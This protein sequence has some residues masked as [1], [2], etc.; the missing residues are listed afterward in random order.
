MAL[1]DQELG[2]VLRYLDPEYREAWEQ[3]LLD[4]ADLREWGVEAGVLTPSATP[5]PGAVDQPRASLDPSA[6]G[7]S[8][9]E[10]MGS[11]V[12]KAQAGLQS[13][14][15][16]QVQRAADADYIREREEA[17]PWHRRDVFDFVGF[18]PDERAVASGQ[19]AA[20]ANAAVT[21]P[22]SLAP[23]SD[24]YDKSA[25]QVIEDLLSARTANEESAQAALEGTQTGWGEGLLETAQDVANSP[26][27]MLSVIGG[28]TAALPYATTYSREYLAARQ[29][30]LE[31]EDADKRAKVQAAI[32]GG[33]SAVPTGRVGRA[34]F[35]VLGDITRTAGRVAATAG[36]EAASET[37]TTAAQ[38]AAD[39]YMAENADSEKLRDYAQFN[40]P[41]DIT[42]LFDVLWRSFKAG[43]LGGTVM[44]T[45]MEI[46]KTAA[47]HGKLAA[48]T[49]RTAEQWAN[50]RP[51]TDD[52][53]PAPPEIEEDVA[54]TTAI[55]P[56][57][58]PEQIEAERDRAWEIRATE[59]AREA[60]RED[61]R[62]SITARVDQVRQRVEELQEAVEGGDRSPAT[63]SAFAAANRDL[64]RAEQVL[65]RFDVQQ[66]PQAPEL[67][68]TA[69]VAEE[70]SVPLGPEPPP[71]ELAEA[72]QK[73]LKSVSNVLK[74]DQAKVRKAALTARSKARTN[75]IRE[76]AASLSALNET[77][78]EQV[79]ADKLL[80]WESANPVENFY[81]TAPAQTTRNPR[82]RTQEPAPV[83]ET[84]DE[85]R[86]NYR[87][88]FPEATEQEI[89]QMVEQDSRGSEM[90]VDQ[91][92]RTVGLAN[93]S[94][95]ATSNLKVDDVVKSLVNKIGKGSNRKLA[96]MIIDGNMRIVETEADIPGGSVPSGTAGF[97]DGNTM[98]IVA[99]RLS[100]KNIVGDMLEIAAHE[101][102][103]AADVAPNDSLK[104]TMGDFVGRE[105]N[106]RLVRKI[107][108]LAARGN[109]V[110]Q[111]AVEQANAADQV[112]PGS[113]DLELTAYFI[114]EARNQRA[115]G[116]L[117]GSVMGDIVSA[118]RTAAKNILPGDYDIDVNDVAY[119]SD[120]LINT[121]AEQGSRLATKAD[122]FGLPMVMGE[123]APDFKLAEKEGRVYISKDGK[124]KFLMSDAESDL[125]LTPKI[126]TKL[127]RGDYLQL[128]EI[129]K[130]P[131][132]F[133]NYPKLKNVMVSVNQELEAYTATHYSA[134]DMAKIG[135][136][137][138]SIIDIS[139]EFIKD[140]NAGVS[141]E[142]V[143]RG[144]LLHEAQHEIQDIEESARGGN[145]SMFM[146]TADRQLMAK[147]TQQRNE[148]LGAVNRILSNT[149]A[150]GF[151][152]AAM[153]QVEKARDAHQRGVISHKELVSELWSAMNRPDNELDESGLVMK[154]VLRDAA[155][156]YEDSSKK[157]KQIVRDAYQK[158]YSLLGEQEAYNTQKNR[159]VRQEDLPINP[160]DP[161]ALGGF[162]DTQ[163]T[164]AIMYNGQSLVKTD[165]AVNAPIY[166]AMQG[167]PFNPQVLDVARERLL[168]PDNKVI[169]K[170]KQLILNY[171]GLGKELGQM[172]ERAEGMAAVYAHKGMKS[173]TRLKDGIE[174]MAKRTNQT[175]EQVEELI[176]KRMELI[177]D[178]PSEQRRASAVGAFIRENPELV[179][180]GEAMTEVTAL[181]K[182]LL[183]QMLQ[184]NSNPTPEELKLMNTINS[185]HY[186][187][188]TQMYSAFQG[189]EGRARNE[190]LEKEYKLSKDMLRRKGEI[191]A[192]LRPSFEV[193]TKAQD[194]LIKNELTI[195]DE[196]TL[197]S[198]SQSR[199]DNLYSTWVG[200]AGRLKKQLIHASRQQGMTVAQAREFTNQTM[201]SALLERADTVNDAQ[202][203]GKA[204]TLIRA[205]LD[206][207][208]A[209]TPFAQY[210]RG[211]KQDRSILENRVK[212]PQE[213]RDLYGEIH[214][215]AIKLAVTIAKQGELAG[216]TR[217]LMDMKQRGTGKWVI[218]PQDAG[219][220][221]NE[222]FTAT[223]QGET[224]GPLAGWRTTPEIA[225]AIGDT[226][227]M[228]STASDALAKA[229]SN[230]DAAVMVGMR[231]V[232]NGLTSVASTQKLMTVVLDLYN[233]GMNAGGSSLV[234][235]ANGITNVKA[236]KNALGVGIESIIDTA[237]DG[238]SRLSEE[239]EFKLEE[240]VRFGILDSARVQEIRRTPQRFVRELISMQP[241][242][243]GK[244]R[245]V[246]RRA[247]N[248]TI[249]AYAMV[250]AWV[251][252]A[253]FEARTDMLRRF[254]EAEGVSKQLSQIKEE[255]ANTI[256]DTNITYARTPA[257]VRA[258]ERTGFTSF[259]PYFVSVF[260]ALGY[261]YAVG[262]QDAIRAS[263]ASTPQGKAIMGGESAK[264]LAG[265]SAAIFGVTAAMK[266]VAALINDEPEEEIAYMQKLMF[267]DARFADSIYMGK[268]PQGIPSFFRMSRIDP[269]GPAT[270][271]LR[272]VFDETTTPEDKR[273]FL[274]DMYK[275]MVITNRAS[276]GIINFV[277]EYV[278]DEA[279]ADKN[280]KFERV[281]GA[282]GE[283]IKEWIEK[284]PSLDYA[285]AEAV[286]TFI[287]SMTPGVIDIID[288]RN[289]G[290]AESEQESKGPAYD[291]LSNLI[292][293][294]GGR[295]DKANP[296]LAAYMAGKDLDNI[297][298]E[299]RG[300]LNQGVLQGRDSEAL[301]AL[302][303]EG[304][305]KEHDA[306]VQVMDVYDGAV[307]G[308]KIPPVQALRMLKDDGSL[309]QG[310]IMAVRLGRENLD[311]EEWI[312]RNSRLVLRSSIENTAEY[313]TEGM[314]DEEKQQRKK[315]IET[316]LRNMR[317]LYG[318]NTE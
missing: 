76:Q 214:D 129:L 284:I 82:T 20:L 187:Y 4:D 211:L 226:L 237:T 141:G 255:A 238:K 150:I 64:R 252:I 298:K 62:S 271:A 308:M 231:K 219:L 186:R 145:Y 192:R 281:T 227:E 88:A 220:E 146:T 306:F 182:T 205:M 218:P 85:M 50:T 274:V 315:E 143:L 175:P 203:Q 217:L 239:F 173:F 314:T 169:T 98:Y 311:M 106:E 166:S 229:Y 7:T 89:E 34:A 100:S 126:M 40:L 44:S 161:E 283:A 53:P 174:Q 257:L 302:F 260:R 300:R 142:D 286:I 180:L 21:E 51:P 18:G 268:D 297:R 245:N 111:R 79:L 199:L 124:R 168:S 155:L 263:A 132:L 247:K 266:A 70:A 131:K 194:Y 294:S 212:L 162:T 178:I 107:D 144:V 296:S 58:T 216:R 153:I 72:R 318:V 291:I 151:S 209:G 14:A 90:S 25:Q 316:F 254:Y 208:D 31:P 39:K 104:A 310:D 130:H 17:K 285:D 112:N 118:V 278:T 158:Y 2:K 47:E 248:T 83:R 19:L 165:T 134:K 223:L 154:E 309:T 270:D 312:N 293:W 69:P 63:L 122:P 60:N 128:N 91:L 86:N 157:L 160:E 258:L 275:D 96:K 65:T 6:S 26:E 27:S 259:M 183:R 299:Y 288:P 56:T 301:Q 215:P 30:G 11:L 74:K 253:A 240:A 49:L 136:P 137:N 9:M 138:N 243:L 41:K 230:S 224:F 221:G 149:A 71:P 29:A 289:T 264:R 110:A 133:K 147:N 35:S 249:E 99:N 176:R 36:R 290:T 184:D 113:R 59:R 43:A 3:G 81:S 304:A 232:T 225:G 213:I 228:F 12:D 55:E 207:G 115:K 190:Q 167:L 28:P 10:G 295:L 33:I 177:A 292:T 121:V 197:N 185:N 42:S 261:N 256:K 156:A 272:I 38:L 159:N 179:S 234:L 77:D 125:N 61:M 210:Y 276:V 67:P 163:P 236:I 101:V 45:P 303:I 244:T 317:A 313:K 201:I 235:L 105:N 66:P 195:P 37:V 95:R 78:R 23:G 24:L 84:P 241:K 251:K 164:D 202:L 282:T 22:S 8:F 48:D 267:P 87:Q 170:A 307:N 277:H 172:V 102:K 191:P 246:A 119:L 46:V 13:T 171:G 116:G 57:A 120:K 93:A 114:N 109:P 5:E 200:D 222:R 242:A 305:Q 152:D 73:A 269:F 189:A 68:S 16:G 196:Q 250:D 287:D 92:K 75:F 135:A 54:P 193:W 262:V 117:V 1:S 103:H 273:R 198:V 127:M 139:P 52:T 265:T 123:R 148:Y 280:T 140:A 80:D 15:A 32:E 188:V 181:S 204:D 108:A 94:G 206:L 97:Y 279:L 233:F